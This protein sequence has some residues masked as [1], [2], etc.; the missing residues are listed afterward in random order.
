MNR[1][2]TLEKHPAW[3]MGQKGADTHKKRPTNNS[4]SVAQRVK[5]GR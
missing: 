3:L 4:A 5:Y 1:L 2:L